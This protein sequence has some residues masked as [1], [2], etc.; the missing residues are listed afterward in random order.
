[1]EYLG[2]QNIVHRDLATRN[3]LVAT[4]DMVKISDFGLAQTMSSPSQY[5]FMQTNRELPIQW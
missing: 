5:Y 2:E 1:M 4:P 3:I